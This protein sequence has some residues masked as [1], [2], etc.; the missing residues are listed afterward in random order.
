MTTSSYHQ[1]GPVSITFQSLTALG[2]DELIVLS[3]FL[4]M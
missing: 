3:S 2:I 1:R 4:P